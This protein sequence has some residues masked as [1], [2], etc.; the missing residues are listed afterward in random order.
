[1]TTDVFCL[2]ALGRLSTGGSTVTER[3]WPFHISTTEPS[4][5]EDSQVISFLESALGDGFLPYDLYWMV[6]GA[7][8]PN[9]RCGEVARRGGG[10]RYWEVIFAEHDAEVA[11]HFIDGYEPAANAVLRWLHGDNYSDIFRDL[12]VAV[13]VKP[14]SGPPS[15]DN[16]GGGERNSLE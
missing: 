4:S 8:A 7:T 5:N 16:R 10:G 6:F 12:K 13:I 15:L 2:D 11:S 1:M 3:Y 14:Y 9:G